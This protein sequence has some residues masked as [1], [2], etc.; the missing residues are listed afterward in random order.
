MMTDRKKLPGFFFDETKGRYFAIP[1]SGIIPHFG[2]PQIKKLHKLSHQA[3]RCKTE[4]S[5]SNKVQNEIEEFKKLQ[6]HKAIEIQRL[7]DYTV[8]QGVIN[9]QIQ[10]IFDELTPFPNKSRPFQ[11]VMLSAHY[12]IT[13]PS[14]DLSY[15]SILITG[16]AT[17]LGEF[18]ILIHHKNSDYLSEVD[19]EL[20]LNSNISEYSEDSKL[21]RISPYQLDDNYIL[22]PACNNSSRKINNSILM[23]RKPFICF[24]EFCFVIKQSTT[25]AYL[26]LID[27]VTLNGLKIRLKVRSELLTATNLGNLCCFGYRNGKISIF[28]VRKPEKQILI[29]YGTVPCA[30]ALMSSKTSYFCVV[31]GINNNL[32]SY[33][34]NLELGKAMLSEIFN[35]HRWGLRVSSNIKVDPFLE[36][37]FAV[38]SESN[39][40]KVLELHFYSLM[41]DKPLMMK[42]GPF[43]LPNCNKSEHLWTL[44]NKNIIIY[45]QQTSA[46]KI[47]REYSQ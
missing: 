6:V 42:H 10:K 38:E 27:P 28:D 29:D 4:P 2:S 9:P 36:G 45:E 41:C 14:F 23:N 32:R 24:D 1:N 13:T 39:D 7:F 46:F 26:Q 22:C 11:N 44:G 34:L 15:F 20:G 8:L 35:E 17:N 30:V 16:K 19:S 43:K 12:F 3:K 47:F 31:S 33:E 40:E 25:Q 21:C 18:K 5:Y 37:I